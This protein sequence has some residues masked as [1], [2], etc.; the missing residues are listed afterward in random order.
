M[1]PRGLPSPPCEVTSAQDDVS[2]AR[3][4]S[5]AEAAAGTM[6][7]LPRVSWTPTSRRTSVPVRTRTECWV[8][9]GSDHFPV[10]VVPP[11][12]G[13]RRRRLRNAAVTDR[14]LDDWRLD[15]VDAE[16]RTHKLLHSTRSPLETGNGAVN[17]EARQS[18]V[19]GTVGS[20]WTETQASTSEQPAL[21]ARRPVLRLRRRSSRSFRC[22]RPALP[23]T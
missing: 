3:S 6:H 5:G 21:R 2:T 8:L 15:A 23:A 14:P 22:L 20:L 4:R 1:P 7:G 13:P 10:G 17:V 12:A 11:E 18:L 9:R 19:S 16:Q